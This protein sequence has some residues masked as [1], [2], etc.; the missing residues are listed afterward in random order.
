VNIANKAHKASDQQFED[1]VVQDSAGP[2]P[3]ITENDIKT[4]TGVSPEARMRMLAWQKRDGMPEPLA[5]V[6]QGTAMD[7]MKKINLPEDDPQRIS[8]LRPIRDAYV[9]GTLTRQDEEWLEKRFKEGVSPDGSSL[10]KMQERVIKAAAFDKSTLM[11]KDTTG[12]L[13]EYNYRQYVDQRVQDYRKANKDPHDLF[14][15]SKPDFIGKPEII[16]YF[17]STLDE[18]IKSQIQKVGSG[19]G[20]PPPGLVVPGAGPVAP[21]APALRQPGESINDF[22]KRTGKSIP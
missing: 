13:A 10:T 20:A 21:G 8:D 4:A 6:S 14:N 22:M 19:R 16:N 18:Q 2:S 7:L 3:T 5:K 15:A 12:P 1:S 17:R 9:N 11:S